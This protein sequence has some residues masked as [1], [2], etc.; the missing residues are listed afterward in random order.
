MIAGI[1]NGSQYAILPVSAPSQRFDIVHF[2]SNQRRAT[3]LR[4]T[5]RPSP[6]LLSLSV[7]DTSQILIPGDL[8]P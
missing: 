5:L 8:I 2:I 4:V 3:R 1:L 6:D 7:R